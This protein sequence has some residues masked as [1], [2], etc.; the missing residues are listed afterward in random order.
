MNKSRHFKNSKWVESAQSQPSFVAEAWE[1]RPGSD[2][3]RS[4]QKPTADQVYISCQIIIGNTLGGRCFKKKIIMRQPSTVEIKDKSSAASSTS[5][6]ST[7]QCVSFLPITSNRWSQAGLE[8]E[9]W[10]KWSAQAVLEDH[11]WCVEW[12]KQ[13]L[14]YSFMVPVGRLLLHSL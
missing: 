11:R 1:R 5:Y 4:G 12:F 7:I 10:A 13:S 2:C 9:C 3:S 8:K 6:Y 14:C